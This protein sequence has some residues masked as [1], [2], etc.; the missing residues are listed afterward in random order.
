MAAL[1]L[2]EDDELEVTVIVGGNNTRSELLDASLT[3]P[4]RRSFCFE[5]SR[6][7]QN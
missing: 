7:W 5:M 3:E 2:I 1:K 4:A 6:I